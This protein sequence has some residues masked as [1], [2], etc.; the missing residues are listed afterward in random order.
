MQ[1]EDKLTVSAIMFLYS[2]TVV[3]SWAFCN[4]TISFSA[5]EDV[6]LFESPLTA[7]LFKLFVSTS[8]ML[9]RW[10]LLVTLLLLAIGEVLVLVVL[11]RLD[12][13]LT[14]CILRFS[15]A[16]SSHLVSST[17]WD[18]DDV[19]SGKC[20]AKRSFTFVK[21]ALGWVCKEKMR[22]DVKDLIETANIHN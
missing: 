2:S 9:F 13:L 7:L 17:P 22:D 10:L 3:L 6:E 18:V 8:L 5:A 1:V 11:L 14:S 12:L 21:S 19:T 15:N 20:C 4:K 16:L